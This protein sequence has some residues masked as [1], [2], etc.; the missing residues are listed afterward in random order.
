M[1]FSMCSSWQELERV[2]SE[3]FSAEEKI[4]ELESQQAKAVDK[5]EQQFRQE[6]ETLQEYLKS[7]EKE[8]MSEIERAKVLFWSLN[9]FPCRSSQEEKINFLSWLSFQQPFR[10]NKFTGEIS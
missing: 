5:L 10:C 7:Q 4:A 1:I 3:L 8:Y 6:M 9:F 2:K